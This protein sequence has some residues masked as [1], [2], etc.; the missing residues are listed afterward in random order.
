MSVSSQ[1]ILS[2]L[3]VSTQSSQ[4][5]IT[6]E[7][8]L[9]MWITIIALDRRTTPSQSLYVFLSVPL[10]ISI[11]TLLLLTTNM[12]ASQN[13]TF[14]VQKSVFCEAFY[15][16]FAFLTLR[17]F[18]ILLC[19]LSGERSFYLFVTVAA[20]NY[21]F[22]RSLLSLLHPSILAPPHFLTHERGIWNVKCKVLF[23]FI[24]LF[25]LSGS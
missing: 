5:W 25:P 10:H 16:S 18:F 8:Y 14:S 4:N 24:F 17:H 1:W 7:L 13:I 12:A 21:T 2:H 23:I 11:L 22:T 6:V 19:Q 9:W 15:G 3:I 20:L